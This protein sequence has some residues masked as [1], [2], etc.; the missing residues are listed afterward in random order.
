M[1]YWNE[2]MSTNFLAYFE[3]EQIQ[4]SLFEEHTLGKGAI[5]Y[6]VAELADKIYFVKSGAFKA[7]CSYPSGRKFIKEIYAQGEIF[8]ELALFNAYYLETTI[9][10][11]KS[12]VLSIEKNDFKRLMAERLHVNSMIN[13]L[14]GQRRIQLEKRFENLIF[15]DSKTRVVEFLLMLA[16]QKGRAV[17]FEKEVKINLTHQDI[18][19]INFTSRQ[20]VTILMNELKSK[21]IISFN[22]RRILFRDLDQLRTELNPAMMMTS[23]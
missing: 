11:E 10:L 5:L 21:K 14:I 8:G 4:K 1:G 20:K 22:R 13:M 15:K 19:R 17:G 9:A 7:E 16:D 2:N 6:N 12:V 3:K 23:E 18:A